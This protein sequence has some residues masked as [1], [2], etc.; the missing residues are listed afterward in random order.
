MKALIPFS[1]ENREIRVVTIDGEPWFVAKDIVEALEYSDATLSNIGDA[2]K[3]VPEEWKGRFPIPTP[4][5]TQEMLTL[6]ESCLLYTS[7]S[8]RDRTRSRMPSSA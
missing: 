7:P 1:F 4:G 5:G 8:P 6:S 2:V 3:H